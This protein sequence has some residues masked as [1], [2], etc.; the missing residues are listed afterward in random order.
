LVLFGFSLTEKQNSGWSL[1]WRQTLRFQ[2][3]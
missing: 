3:K 2:W 1:L